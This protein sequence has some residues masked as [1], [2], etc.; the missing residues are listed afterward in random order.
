MDHVNSF[1]LLGDNGLDIRYGPDSYRIDPASFHSESWY[2]QGLLQT[3]QLVWGE[4]TENCFARSSCEYVMPVYRNFIDIHGG[5]KL[6]SIV[7]LLD[8]SFF[9]QSYSGLVTEQSTA[10]FIHDS[11]GRLFYSH[12]SDAAEREIN[13]AGFLPSSTDVTPYFEVIENGQSF[14]VVQAISGKT[15]TSVTLVT[16]LNELRRQRQV[17]AMTTLVLAAGTTLLVSA[18]SLFLSQNLSKPAWQL[19]ETVDRIADGHFDQEIVL[20]TDDEFGALGVAIHRMAQQIE[21]LLQERVEGEIKLLQ[22]QIN[23]HFLHN[24]LNSIKWMATLQGADG[25]REMVSSLGRLLRAVMGSVNQKI[26]IAEELALLD[27]YIYIQKIRYRN[28]ITYQRDLQTTDQ[29]PPL[30]DY[31]IPKF[32]LQPLV[33]NAIFHGIEPKEGSGTIVVS[34]QKRENYL[35][36]SVWDDGVGIRPEEL[37]TLLEPSQPHVTNGVTEKIGLRN[38]H[39]QIQL[40]YGSEYGLQIESVEGSYT[41]VALKLPIEVND[42]AENSHC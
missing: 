36:V 35:E 25:I 2:Q 3:S 32:T 24:T 7:L 20:Q 37:A 21:K 17:I 22:S 40:I 16:Q 19:M 42:H 41:R 30:T 27:D 26:T 38:I 6:G 31:L 12:S 23:P 4:V 18:F 15:G 8:P 29:G 14:L 28:K 10:L 13:W 34:V 11:D 1:F 39:N 9:R 33:E 5:K